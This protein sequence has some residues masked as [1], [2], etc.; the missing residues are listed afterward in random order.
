LLKANKKIKM[1]KEWCYSVGIK[2]NS[3]L[4]TLNIIYCAGSSASLMVYRTEKSA[5]KE[6]EKMRRISG[7]GDLEGRVVNISSLLKEGIIKPSKTWKV[8]RRYNRT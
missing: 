5:Q 4:Y 2:E 8:D 1:K 7:S 6:I 3:G